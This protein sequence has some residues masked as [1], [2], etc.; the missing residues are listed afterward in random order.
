MVYVASAISDLV[1][2]SSL[3]VSGTGG[4]GKTCLVGRIA[5]GKFLG[6]GDYIP[7]LFDNTHLKYTSSSGQEILLEIYE[8]HSREEYDRLRPLSYTT[9]SLVLI[10][11]P[12]AVKR[13]TK[14]HDDREDIWA[15]TEEVVRILLILF[16]A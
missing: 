6:E 3:I 15:K 7:T 2:K 14:R 11:Y 16:S 4:I 8:A 13:N 5:S 1:L 9:A 10:C 12:C